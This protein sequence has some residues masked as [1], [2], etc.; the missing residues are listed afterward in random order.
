MSVSVEKR[1]KSK[2]ELVHVVIQQ[3]VVSICCTFRR[4]VVASGETENQNYNFFC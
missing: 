4:S 2:C 1:M 3:T